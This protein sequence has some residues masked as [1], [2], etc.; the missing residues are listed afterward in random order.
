MDNR[1]KNYP[2][3]KSSTPVFS[4]EDSEA[5]FNYL[6]SSGSFSI[7]IVP[8]MF[9]KKLY[10]QNMLMQFDSALDVEIQKGK[11]KM[12]RLIVDTLKHVS[13]PLNGG[14]AFSNSG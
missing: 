9:M 5:I 8:K 11:L 13:G 12:V 4:N 14:T 3:F 1:G 2:W 7:L 10:N 6:T